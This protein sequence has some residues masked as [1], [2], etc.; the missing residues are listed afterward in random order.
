MH[1]ANLVQ[2]ANAVLGGEQPLSD[3]AK[4]VGVLKEARVKGSGCTVQ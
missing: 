3:L 2:G 4:A 1:A